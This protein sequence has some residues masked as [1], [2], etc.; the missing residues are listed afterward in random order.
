LFFNTTAK[1]W[2]QGRR[3]A[4]HSV[5]QVSH[6]VITVDFLGG[7]CQL[8]LEDLPKRGLIPF[9]H[10]G[11]EQVAG[12]SHEVDEGP[13]AQLPA[14]TY[15]G[16]DVTSTTTVRP[17]SDM[18]GLSSLVESAA[19]AAVTGGAAAAPASGATDAWWGAMY[20]LARRAPSSSGLGA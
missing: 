11:P 20:A 19:M 17:L 13:A 3:R 7:C 18:R 1:R 12:R 6:L 9:D 16:M 10:S 4:N 2:Q 5:E 8:G 15:D 14:T